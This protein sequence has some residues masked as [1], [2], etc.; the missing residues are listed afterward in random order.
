[1]ADYDSGLQIINVSNPV[2]PTSAGGC[3]TLGAAWGVF[4]SGSHAYVAVNDA[5]LQ[6]INVSNPSGPVVTGS[7]NTPGHAN[8]IFVSGRYAYVADE[9]SGLQI[10]D[11][12]NPASPTLVG[13]YDTPGTALGVFV[14]GDY[15]YVADYSSLMILRFTPT[16]I[17]ESD[18]LPGDFSL[19]QNSPNPF[20]SSTV[21]RYELPAASQVKLD[22]YDILGRKVQSLLD[23]KEQ[24]GAH[25]VV[26]DA[27]GFSSGVYFYHLQAGDRKYSRR[28]TVI[29]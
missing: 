14:M 16:G 8:S 11:I 1:V 9:G 5:G 19:S 2:N 18:N 6:I 20:N 27:E 25:Q 29:K 13:G 3:H 12:S 23:I 21:I 26:W 24:A 4:V 28:M 17:E 10:I 7:Y 22:I 15:I